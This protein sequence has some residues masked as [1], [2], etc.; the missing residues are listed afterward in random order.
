MLVIDRTTG[1]SNVLATDLPS[2][3]VVAVDGN[4]LDIMGE[5][6]GNVIAV[7]RKGGKPTLLIPAPS[8]DWSCHTTRWIRSDASGLRWLRMLPEEK[9]GGLFS[10]P[11]SML[12]DPI[13][14]WRELIA[15]Q[16]QPGP[17]SDEP[18]GSDLDAP[19][20]KP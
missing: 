20:P 7:P 9:R 4:R 12:A 11:R 5:G 17:G 1:E 18:S 13:K 3:T 6:H 14:Q 16:P 8:A 10:I 15:K 19:G 2:P